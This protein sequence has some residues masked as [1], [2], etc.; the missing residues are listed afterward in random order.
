MLYHQP[1]QPE[2]DTD[3]LTTEAR[4]VLTQLADTTFW[5][6]CQLENYEKNNAHGVSA[7][8]FQKGLGKDHKDFKSIKGAMKRLMIK[9]NPDFKEK[10]ALLTPKASKTTS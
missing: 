4:K 8:E 7:K 3:H 5:T 6:F 2:S 9:I 10:L 1:T